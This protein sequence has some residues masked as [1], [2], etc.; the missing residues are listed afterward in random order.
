MVDYNLIND[1]GI[2][3]SLIEK[4][5]ADAF[6]GDISNVRFYSCNESTITQ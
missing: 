4:E 1:L 2:D 3:E 5:L 6:D